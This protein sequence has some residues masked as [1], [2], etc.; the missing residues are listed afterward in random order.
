MQEKI[1]VVKKIHHEND[2]YCNNKIYNDENKDNILTG[3]DR[4][5]E[6]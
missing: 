3:S 5:I 2:Y 4:T 6:K 1:Q